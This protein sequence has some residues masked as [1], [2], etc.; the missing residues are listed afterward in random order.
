M[1]SFQ[2]MK[3][4]NRS[5]VLQAIR[6][7]TSGISRASI[8][9]R[10]GLTAASVTNIVTALL[11]ENLVRETKAGASSGGRKPILLQM[12]NRAQRIVGIDI[13]SSELRIAS[14][15]LD[16]VL[17]RSR[18][19]AIP[20]QVTENTFLSFL[21]SSLHQFLSE[22]PEPVLGIGAAVHGIVD[23][24]S[25]VSVHAPAHGIK[26]VPLRHALETAFGLPIST[27]NDVKAMALAESWYGK[28]RTYDSFLFI[29]AGRGLGAAYVENGR[30]AEGASGIAG[31]IGHTLID[32]NG[33]Q[34]S[35]GASGCLQTLA[36]AEAL[37]RQ[38]NEATEHRPYTS[39]ADVAAA[40][41]TDPAAAEALKQIGTW[42][43]YALV[44]AVHTFNP[45]AVVFGGGLSRNEQLMETARK[46]AYP[47]FLTKHAADTDIHVSTLENSTLRGAC[48][49]VLRDHI[50][51]EPEA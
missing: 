21:T 11:Q 10:T 26:G 40:A 48:S 4:R 31:E 9:D 29:N 50:L 45:S 39:G 41:G 13:G 35:C 24:R 7:S 37:V 8:A 17:L 49:L 14:A 30:V 42:L 22:E 33:V 18:T 2:H 3:A 16:T 38:A 23:R 44:N 27:C 43:G 12:N 1:S 47:R 19:I 5:R 6:Q 20:E 32:P 25:G 46:A 51:Q 28:G 15:G 36:S 34:C